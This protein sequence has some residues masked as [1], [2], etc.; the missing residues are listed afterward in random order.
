M[1]TEATKT[2]SSLSEALSKVYA[3]DPGVFEAETIEEMANVREAQSIRGRYI[4][5]KIEPAIET[6]FKEM[7]LDQRGGVAQI[8]L[9]DYFEPVRSP[10]ISK[11]YFKAPATGRGST[12]GTAPN[13]RSPFRISVQGRFTGRRDTATEI[14]NHLADHIDKDGLIIL[15]LG[16]TPKGSGE[17]TRLDPRTRN[18]IG[19]VPTGSN[20]TMKH[21]VWLWPPNDDNRFSSLRDDEWFK[22]CQI[23]IVDMGTPNN[24]IEIK[25][26]FKA[27]RF[28]NPRR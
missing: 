15:P 22:I 11:Y 12:S 9:G 5:N 10:G 13:V 2:Y 27:S 6:I 24:H 26:G 23:G 19:V 7:Y 16:V 1:D 21:A 3:D 4:S 20:D 25:Y 28:L 14:F 18:T 8:Q 17:G